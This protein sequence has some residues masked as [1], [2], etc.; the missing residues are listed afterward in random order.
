[1]AVGN[2][3]LEL[4]ASGSLSRCFL[5]SFAMQCAGGYETLNGEAVCY[6]I[7]KAKVWIAAALSAVL[8]LFLAAL[9]VWVYVVQ[10]SAT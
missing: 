3:M 4:P 8:V 2:Y 5:T 1:L 6:E 7:S 10:E 9:F